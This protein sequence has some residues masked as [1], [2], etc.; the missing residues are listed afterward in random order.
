M[1]QMV[2]FLFSFLPISIIHAQ[3]EKNIVIS[4]GQGKVTSGTSTLDNY[5]NHQWGNFYNVE[6]DCYLTKRQVLSSSFGFGSYRFYDPNFVTPVTPVYSD[7]ANAKMEYYAFS[8]IYKYGFIYKP[9]FSA[10]IGTGASILTEASE[11][12]ATV[13][14]NSTG[15]FYQY[16]HQTAITDL[17]FPVRLEAAYRITKRVEFG[18]FGGFYCNPDQLI[19]YH[20]CLKLGVLLK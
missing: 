18:A 9:K 15:G 20:A 8:L 4:Y 19:G 2:I 17:Y 7:G 5:S 10:F 6:L 1:K 11:R 13:Y 12:T 14:T 16:L 3:Q